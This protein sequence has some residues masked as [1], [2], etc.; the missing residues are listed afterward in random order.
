VHSMTWL[1]VSL[2]FSI[3]AICHRLLLLP[4]AR[5]TP[6]FIG[7]VF[8]ILIGLWFVV[9]QR[10]QFIIEYVA[11]QDEKIEG[12]EEGLREQRS[13]DF[14]EIGRSGSNLQRAL[15]V[16]PFMGGDQDK[17]SIHQRYET[18]MMPLRA[19]QVIL[20]LISYNFA[21]TVA[22]LHD[23]EDYF[24]K[25]LL[26]SML[27]VVLFGLLMAVLPSQVVNFIA[28][29]ALPPY[30]DSTNL[31]YFYAVIEQQMTS[32]DRSKCRPLGSK[33][34]SPSP[35]DGPEDGTSSAALRQASPLPGQAL[36]EDSPSGSSSLRG[37]P[38]LLEVNHDGS[39]STRAEL[40]SHRELIRRLEERVRSLELEVDRKP[41]TD[42]VTS[43]QEGTSAE[44]ASGE[45]GPELVRSG[46]A[47][48]RQAWDA[49]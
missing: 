32:V 25:T 8:V 10:Q 14:A 27:F 49:D 9:R 21:R 5:F 46:T 30:V 44:V 42:E 2:L 16:L 36:D 26:F 35:G 47:G 11:S 37:K 40:D 6:F 19:L 17:T 23:W 31:E 3:F 45:L 7:F 12:D 48:T 34:E 43:L 29:M 1:M 20:F 4:L 33:Q 13:L 22:D 15:G 41:L 18:Q 24:E 28:M 38:P 39:S